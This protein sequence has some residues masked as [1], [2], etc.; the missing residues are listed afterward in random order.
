M[1]FRV[2][3]LKIF[4][5]VSS[6][7]GIAASYSK[8]Y[9]FHILF[10]C[11]IIVYSSEIIKSKKIEFDRFLSLHK[12]FYFM[13]FWYFISIVWSIDISASLMYIFYIIFGTFLSLTIIS[14][15]YNLE[16]QN[17]L[18]NV[19]AY[20]FI[21][22]ILI[23]LL[24]SFTTFRFPISPYSD[25]AYLFGKESYLNN[26]NE[27]SIKYLQETPTGFQ[28]NPN[29]LAITML[30]V[31]PF[32]IYYKNKFIKIPGIISVFIIILMSGSRGVFIACIFMFVL[33]FFFT[34][35]KRLIYSF[36]FIPI[37]IILLLLSNN[38]IQL[39]NYNTHIS[40]II[41]SFDALSTYLS[42]ESEEKNS[43]S[44][45]QVFIKNALNALS[46]SSYLGVGPGGAVIANGGASIHNFW[47]ELLTDSGLF[48]TIIF[49]VWYLYI[50]FRLY[51]I[52]F[53]SNNELKYYAEACFLALSSFLIGAVSA[54]SV[55]YFFPMWILLGFSISTIYNF[56]RSKNEFINIR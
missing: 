30:I 25:Y 31:L 48:F 40:E 35:K 36:L 33:Y 21:I 13:V 19:M 39:I 17:R 11:L 23:C 6:I 5:I 37:I 54:S 34:S 55:I 44:E 28:W 16:K 1:I 46:N 38:F 29:N 50:L 51:I 15:S 20:I 49:F 18:F 26:V 52:S 9:L 2:E 12:F 24:E 32:F 10:V 27:I 22:E 41:S 43:I 3:S 7:L 14:Y 56:K 42:G 45:R 47:I 8:V 53:R 4:F